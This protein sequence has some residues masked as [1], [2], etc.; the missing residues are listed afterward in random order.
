MGTSMRDRVSKALV[1]AALAACAGAAAAQDWPQWRGPAR[2]GLAGKGAAARASWPAALAQAWKVN[3]GEGHA[4]PVVAG[5]RVYVFARRGEDEV[6]E[7]L[8]LASGKSLWKQPHPAP[9][10]MN[11]AAR[12]HGKGPKATP[13]VAAGRV[14]TLGITGALTAHDAQN[15]R[16]LWRH[17]FQKRFKAT[18]PIYGTATSPVVDGERVIAHVG[19]E[20]DGSLSAFDAATGVERW[21][22]KGDGPGYASPIVATLA[23]RRQVVTQTQQNVVG[24]AA[25]TGELLWKVP[26]TTAYEQNCVTPVIGGDLLVYSGLD[27]GVSAVRIVKKGAAFAAEPAWTNDEVASYM[28]TPV[29]QGDVLYG[30]SHKKKGQLYALDLATGKTLWLS[31]GRV[32]D[33]AALVS[34]AGTLLALTTDSALI[35]A[36]QDPKAYSV[37]RTYSVADTPTWAHPAPTGDGILVKDR[38]SLALWR[39]P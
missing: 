7:C 39:I 19:G 31:E 34:L 15:G 25:D 24:L 23:G 17:D 4:S 3:V 9:Y 28:S 38:D 10:T 6:L 36:K 37:I 20:N 14:V 16:V 30:L 33:N 12:A 1:M 32:G 35:V 21:S 22:W 29:L 27:K 26:F 2:D 13:V 5:N 18:A 11:P 8:D